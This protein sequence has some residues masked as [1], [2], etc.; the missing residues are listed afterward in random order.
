MTSE[1]APYQLRKTKDRLRWIA[2]IRAHL[3]KLEVNDSD[4]AALDFALRGAAKR[5]QENDND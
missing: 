3:K 2:I 1:Q 5:I 4:T